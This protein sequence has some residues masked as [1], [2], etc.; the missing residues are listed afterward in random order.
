MKNRISTSQEVQ[1]DDMKSYYRFQ[2]KIY[3]AT[4]WTF[5][6]GRNMI[7][8]VLPLDREAPLRILEVGCG[9]GTNM[10]ALAKLFPNAQIEGLDVSQDMISQAENNLKEF[11]DRVSLEAKPYEVDPNRTPVYDVILFSYALTMI[12]PQW[13]ELI[14]QA[15]QDL[16]AGGLVAVVD[17]HEANYDF[18]REFM[19]SHHVN[20]GG[21]LLPA[22]EEIFDTQLAQVRPGLLGVW[23]YL[24]YVGQKTS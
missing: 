4:R 24:L 6:Y 19:S 10:R 11:Q 17:F 20:L 23:S 5:L 16:K 14:V 12:N 13:S 22:L 7:L 15:K 21:H 8:K 18:Y 3:D 9:T 2:A 1:H